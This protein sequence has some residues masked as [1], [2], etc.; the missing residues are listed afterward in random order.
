MKP[1]AF[2]RH[3]HDEKLSSV[4]LKFSHG[5]VAK[6]ASN[7]SSES[8]INSTN[9][10][11]ENVNIESF[12]ISERVSV[13]QPAN[14]LIHFP[15]IVVSTKISQ[16]QIKSYESIS[17]LSSDGPKMGTFNSSGGGG[18]SGM[19]ERIHVGGGG[20]GANHSDQEPYYDTVPIEETDDEIE[21]EIS[22]SSDSRCRNAATSSLPKLF[23]RQISCD[24]GGQ[25]GE[26]VSN[27]IN[28][29]Y[30]LS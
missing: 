13:N 6:S 7:S 17:S 5:N 1:S 26:R 24:V 27:Y 12:P 3:K 9:N 22:N 23:D 28:I 18:G 29:D 8:L 20:G 16:F 2:L 10:N 25:A 4:L 14:D 15:L 21:A 11:E 19:H 30:F